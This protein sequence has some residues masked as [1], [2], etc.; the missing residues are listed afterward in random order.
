[1][2][3]SS[4]LLISDIISR[5][6]RYIKVY[7]STGYPCPASISMPALQT[8][9]ITKDYSGFKWL[10][11]EIEYTQPC[12]GIA[13]DN[14]LVSICRSVRICLQAHEAGLETLEAF[15]GKGYAS[16]AVVGW[17]Q[18]VRKM[19]AAPLY[20]TFCDNLSSQRVAAKCK[21]SVYGVNFTIK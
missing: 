13:V 4:Y 21:L 11:S 19:N 6:N 20:S 7:F 5:R 17:A 14:K 18:A 16:E 12:V 15:R 10:L 2:S 3:Y 1:M 9:S 8:L